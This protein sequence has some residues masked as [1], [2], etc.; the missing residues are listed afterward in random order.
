MFLIMLARAFNASASIFRLGIF[1]A[2]RNNFTIRDYSNETSSFGVTSVTGNAGNLTAQLALQTALSSAVENLSIGHLD[3]Y[4]YVIEGLNSPVTPS[5]VYAQ[6]EIKWLVTYAGDTSG[7]VFQI[8]IAAPN[9][10]DNV[11]P[12]SDVADLSSDDWVAFIAAFEAYARSP[13]N[14]TE[15]VTVQSAKL[16]GRNI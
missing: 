12:N 11:V 15:T 14:G 16:V 7:D 1:M 2:T 6:R 8:E 9:L 3:K 10:T 5:N 13:Q 4:T